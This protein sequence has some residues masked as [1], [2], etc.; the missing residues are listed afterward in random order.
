M[1]LNLLADY[2]DI[3]VKRR[4]HLRGKL[5]GPMEDNGLPTVAEIIITKRPYLDAVLE[6]MLRLRAAM[7]VPR[8]ATD[9]TPIARV[10]HS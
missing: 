10:P 2:P 3:P 7:L 9:D 1:D 6:E 8:D 4:E 5:A